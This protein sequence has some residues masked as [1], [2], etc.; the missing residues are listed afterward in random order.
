[1]FFIII[2][3]FLP[4][5]VYQTVK[6]R[7]LFKDIKIGLFDISLIC[8]AII[9]VISSLLS[10]DIISSFIGNNGWYVGALTVCF[11][12]L[13]YL[14]IS[15]F[16]KYSHMLWLP[17][18]LVL[19][20]VMVIAIF[21]FAGIDVLSM[22]EGIADNPMFYTSTIGNINRFSCLVCIFLPLLFIFFLACDKIFSRIIYLSSFVLCM[23]CGF[24]C[25]CDSFYLGLGF[26]FIFAIPYIFSSIKRL[27][28]TLLLFVISAGLLVL[29]SCLP[30]F[31]RIRD[32]SAGIS[33]IILNIKFALPV[34]AVLIFIYLPVLFLKGKIGIKFLRTAK[35]TV[36]TVITALVLVLALKSFIGFNDASGSYR[37]LI[38]RISFEK[39]SDFPFIQK[40]FGLG[41]EKA[42]LI[43]DEVSTVFGMK[44]LVSHSEF[45]QALITT[46]IVGAAS[47]L[48]I[49]VS[50][51]RNFFKNK[52]FCSDSIAFCL[53]VTAYLSCALVNSATTV[54]LVFVA[55][56]YAMKK[57]YN[58]KHK[59]AEYEFRAE[60][61]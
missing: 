37:G 40:L 10:E 61:S 43:Y 56:I 47:Y 2:A 21:N 26:S 6:Y 51:F 12:V 13:L 57:P 42:Y 46:G 50:F 9:S 28:D 27:S 39:F 23:I 53:P 19:N 33:S 5:I 29:C 44:C 1:M 18:L 15:S 14:Y 7:K 32:N 54:N 35:Y 22:H 11:F 34:F 59:G 16:I 20:A 60:K 45:I 38:Y 41:P 48:F 24:L 36:F 3:A 30:F 17:V 4:F 49:V 25:A 52:T 58:K 31:G 55:L 8:F